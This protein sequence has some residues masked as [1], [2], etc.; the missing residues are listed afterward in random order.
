MDL[1][2]QD[3]YFTPPSKFFY[4]NIYKKKLIFC[5]DGG[6][7]INTVEEI[8]YSTVAAINSKN[9]KF[10]LGGQNISYYDLIKKSK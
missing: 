5:F 4:E 3:V 2:D 7:S 10:I 9:S 1:S 6:I 8:G